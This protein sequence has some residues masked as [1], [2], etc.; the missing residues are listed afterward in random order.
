[1][2]TN[3][4][5]TGP[6]PAGDNPENSTKRRG[7][8]GLN[9]AEIRELN[10][11]EQYVAV[12]SRPERLAVLTHS[13]ITAEFLAAVTEGIKAARGHG[14]SA[15]QHDTGK[16]SATL[17]QQEAKE[18]LI[19]AMRCV[20]AAAKRMYARTQPEKLDDYAV[21]KKIDAS[22]PVLEELSAQMLAKLNTERPPSINTTFITKLAGARSEFM[23]AGDLQGSKQSAASAAREARR[24]LVRTIKDRR[25]EIQYA[26]DGAWPP[27]QP[28]NA[29]IRREFGLPPDRFLSVRRRK[30]A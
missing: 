13:E 5:S 14:A 6:A 15:T 11:A 19:T 24:A 30:A 4:T 1:M 25:L 7:R 9:Q 21:G 26:A 27:G 10:L 2:N 22:R 16:E 23:A 20:Q 29:A 3:E 28:G 12:A 17:S 18:N 8:A